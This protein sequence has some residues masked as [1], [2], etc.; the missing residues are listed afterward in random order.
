MIWARRRAA[1]LVYLHDW[2]RGETDGHQRRK[3]GKATSAANGHKFSRQ[4]APE[5]S[6]Q[7]SAATDH[8]TVILL[9][10]GH[11]RF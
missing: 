5:L 1:G 9:F 2:R 4:N 11:S 7:L 8:T 6:Q 3:S 10:A